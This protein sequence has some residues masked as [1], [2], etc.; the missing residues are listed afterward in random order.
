MES[1]LQES[2]IGLI[3]PAFD[4]IWGE[5]I[6]QSG[7]RGHGIRHHTFNPVTLTANCFQ[8]VIESQTEAEWEGVRRSAARLTVW[9][10]RMGAS[11]GAAIALA[12]G[13][14]RVG[15]RVH[16]EPYSGRRLSGRKR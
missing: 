15:T 4:D 8:L 16:V 1:E 2:L 6:T 5:S 9:L 14:T 7:R 12:D 10:G 13:F 11:A 3:L